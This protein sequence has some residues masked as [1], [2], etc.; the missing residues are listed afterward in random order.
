MQKPSP[1]DLTASEVALD[2]ISDPEINDVVFAMRDA[3]VG[4][5]AHTTAAAACVLLAEC[6]H[7]NTAI[8]KQIANY[9][10]IVEQLVAIKKPA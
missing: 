3:A 8:A 1:S 4:S 9:V 6:L 2:W 10:D 7:N 5:P